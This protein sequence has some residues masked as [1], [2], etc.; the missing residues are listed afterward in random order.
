MVPKSR[1]W[2]NCL[3]IINDNAGFASLLAAARHRPSTDAAFPPP[4]DDVVVRNQFDDRTSSIPP[5]QNPVHVPPLLN[6]PDAKKLNSKAVPACM[7]KGKNKHVKCRDAYDAEKLRGDYAIDEMNKFSDSAKS[8]RTLLVQT[9]ST[10]QSFMKRQQ[11]TLITAMK[12][13]NTLT[14]KNNQLELSLKTA[15]ADG[16]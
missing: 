14:S 3:T 8:F 16:N 1:N 2:G 13:N 5:V 10:N 7:S 12:R 9:N 15:T 4:M 6:A 11:T